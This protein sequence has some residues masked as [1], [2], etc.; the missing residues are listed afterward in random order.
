MRKK[1]EQPYS[2]SGQFSGKSA[3]SN[4]LQVVHVS[5]LWKSDLF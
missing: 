4:S 2:Y 5:D 1:I 3:T